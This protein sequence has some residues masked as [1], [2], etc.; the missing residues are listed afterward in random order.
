VQLHKPE[1]RNPAAGRRLEKL[2]LTYRQMWEVA[3]RALLGPLE[4]TDFATI[5]RRSFLAS[6]PE[7]LGS[8][9]SANP[10]GGCLI[11]G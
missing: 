6:G 1:K 4:S 2:S 3:I 5:V 8:N 7:A 10:A 9:R 11:A